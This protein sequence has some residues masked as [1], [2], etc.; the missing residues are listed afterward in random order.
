M[1]DT[2]PQPRILIVDD[3][4]ENIDILGNALAGYKR[5][6]ALNGEK[7]LQ[8]A[9]SDHLPD[10]I[11]LDVMMP[12][13]D[14]Y[15][16]C[17]RL[18]ADPRTRDVPVIFVTA[19]G[20]VEDETHGFALGAVDYI[21]KPISLPIVQARVKTHLR[22]R[23]LQL[24]LNRQNQH[25]EE[26]VKEK[27]A[28][29]SDSQLATIIALADLAESRDETTGAHIERTRT[30]CRL[31][32]RQLQRN[33]RYAPRINAAFIE[34]LYNAAPLHDVGKVG[35]PDQILRKPGKLLPEEFDI[36]KK[37]TVIGAVT[38]Q[39]TREKY[40]RNALLNMGIA[41]AH[42]HHERWDGRG[43]PEGL[44]GE[45]IPLSARIMAIAD[46][47]DALRSERPYKAALSHAAAVQIIREGVGTQFDP[48]VVAAFEAI[49]GEFARTVVAPDAR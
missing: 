9:W 18:K 41:I 33:P 40:P 26:L 46:V 2:L 10:L 6:V 1:D 31:L 34:S 22:L 13:M 48:G 29:I 37:H 12:G 42:S 47:Y 43:Y 19:K 36:M 14:G 49:E 45:D 32:A 20:E 21:A 25:L 39:K 35:I 7:A 8:R 15:E 11:L 38:L 3:A 23:A 17:R 28:E 30:F 27:V 4:P 24:E 44:A 5:S 16:V